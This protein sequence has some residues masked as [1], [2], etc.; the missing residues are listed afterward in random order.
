MFFI[1]GVFQEYCDLFVVMVIIGLYRF[2]TIFFDKLNSEPIFEQ[3]RKGRMTNL[4]KLA[5]ILILQITYLF[6]FSYGQ[7]E[8]TTSDANLENNILETITIIL[9]YGNLPL[10]FE[11]EPSKK[12]KTP[13]AE[14]YIGVFCPTPPKGAFESFFVSGTELPSRFS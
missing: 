5:L 9:H 6:S 14:T 8:Q 1:A 12:L 10:D 2:Y 7:E 13:Y 4:K 3:K 11:I